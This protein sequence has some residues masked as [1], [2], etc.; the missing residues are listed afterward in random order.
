MKIALIQPKFTFP[1]LCCSPIITSALSDIHTYFLRWNTPNLGLLTIAA[2]IPED[3]DISYIHK[4]AKEIDCFEDFDLVALSC[5]TR[6]AETVYEISSRF[7]KKG[8]YTVVGGIHASVFPEEAHRYAD[9]VFVG[10]AEETFP[11]FLQD[12]RAGQAAEIY[13][14]PDP[15]DLTLSP[16]PRFSIL[17]H[18]Y[19]GYPI[20]TTRGCPH[21]CEFCAASLYGRKYRYKEIDQIIDEIS[22]L[23]SLV[24]NPF[25]VFSDDNLFVNKPRSLKLLEKL[26]PL[27]VEWQAITDV[28]TADDPELLRLLYRA[29]CR[30]IFLG[31]ESL[32]PDHIRNIDPNGWKSRRVKHYQA[33][34]Q[35]IKHEGIRVLG[36]FILG[37][38]DQTPED[39]Q[40][41]K[42]FVLDNHIMPQYS[43]LTPVPG[44]KLYSKYK[45]AGRLLKDKSWRYYNFLDCVFKHPIMTAEELE[46]AIADLYKST[47]T[48]E[49]MSLIIKDMIQAK[50]RNRMRKLS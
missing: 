29:G 13:Q 32:N 43:I 2:Y 48:R 22:Y 28:S 21:G 9:T 44:S 47:F 25:I 1:G 12:F 15:V 37:F 4:E 30:E 33:C 35:K 49:H 36:A 23:K 20:Q 10:E 41:V 34:I 26:I 17:P 38:D 31:L 39:F 7:R 16:K 6:E 11:R 27:K 8:I 50:K 14:S 18:R 42:Q 46:T 40:A 19:P 45:K 3:W 24:S 5:M